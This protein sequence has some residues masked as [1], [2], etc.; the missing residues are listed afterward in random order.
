M[1]KVLTVFK[2]RGDLSVAAFRDYYEGHHVR[3]ALQHVHHFGFRK[4]LRNHVVGSGGDA[5]GFDCLTEFYFESPEQAMQSQGFMVTPEGKLFADDELN[6]LDMGYH[7]S[8]GLLE[9][10]LAGPP[11]G[12]DPTPTH[13]RMWVMRRPAAVD[14]ETF[15][16]RVRQWALAW[17]DRHAAAVR[18]V[19]L[20]TAIAGQLGTPPFDTLVTLWPASS[21]LPAVDAGGVGAGWMTVLDV[22]A[23]EAT[24]AQLGLG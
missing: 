10:V 5:P 16:G 9:E 14:A 2:R 1:I 17:A 8:F 6:F 22:E 3:L 20:D 24:P 11:R 21:D 19:T 18:R 7:P 13:K 15:A 23:I 12:V 4:Y